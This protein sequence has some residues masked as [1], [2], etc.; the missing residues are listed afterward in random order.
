MADYRHAVQS[1][2]RGLLAITRLRGLRDNDKWMEKRPRKYVKSAEEACKIKITLL[3]EE[4]GLPLRHPSGCSMQ[5][6]MLI[7]ELLGGTWHHRYCN[8]FK[9]SP[10]HKAGPNIADQLRGLMRKTKC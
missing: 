9:E 7:N 1:K 6:I 10:P 3:D 2:W 4:G 8:K 5:Y